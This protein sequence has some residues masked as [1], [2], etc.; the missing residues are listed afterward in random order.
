MNETHIFF[1]GEVGMICPITEDGAS[2]MNS[3]GGGGGDIIFS[4]DSSTGSPLLTGSH[5]QATL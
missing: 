5:S 1:F 4:L 2:G 3:R